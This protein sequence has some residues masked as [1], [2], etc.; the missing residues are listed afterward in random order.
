MGNEI[1]DINGLDS[2]LNGNTTEATATQETATATT[3]ATTDEGTSTTEETT[4]ADVPGGDPNLESSEQDNDKKDSDEGAQKEKTGNYN[5]AMAKMR[6]EHAKS[7][8]ALQQLAQAL[9]I[10]ETDPSKLGDRLVDMA[11]QKLAKDAN[12]PVELYKELNSTKEQLAAVQYQ[13]NQITAREKFMSVKEAFGLDDK[14]L[15]KFAEQL[16]KEGINAITNP[17]VDLEYEY[18]KRNRE[19]LEQKRIA[20]AVEEALRK[21]NTAE[22]KSTKPS[23]E[24]GKKE[25]PVD[26]IN[27]VSALN[28]LLDGK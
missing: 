19:A 26:K 14:A 16:D 4:G 10:Q 27:N 9:G 7:Q 8:K 3:A 12:V 22:T 25:E 6:I 20:Q 17:N 23:T 24:Q 18:Y 2:L 1:L 21:S 5:A 11:Q 15:L 13:Q 28:S